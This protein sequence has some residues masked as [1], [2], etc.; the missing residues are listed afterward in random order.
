MRDEW[1]ANAEAWI[2][3]ARTPGLSRQVWMFHLPS[4]LAVVPGPGALTLDIGC[5]EGRVGRELARR[6]HHVIGLD[7]APALA[8]A[9]LTHEDG[10][11]AVAAD[12]AALP[13]A[14]DCCDL[15][16]SVMA[17][18][19]VDDLDSAVSEAGRVLQPGGR[20]VFAILHPYKV[21]SDFGAPYFEP[22]TYRAG[23]A[24]DGLQVELATGYRPMSAY[25]AAVQRAGLLVEAMHEPV[26]DPEVV[27]A[28]PAMERCRRVPCIAIISALKA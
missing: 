13:F 23:G 10:F 6:G 27:A 24:R 9:A 12:A 19:N 2:Q 3:W 8:R 17:L 20:F 11:P 21:A 5:G 1:Q 15:A 28:F 25:F 18:Q 14:D 7:G 4:F 22:F 16:V 26:P